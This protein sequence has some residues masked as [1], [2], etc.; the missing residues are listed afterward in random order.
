MLH[1]KNRK[2][3]YFISPTKFENYLIMKG[4]KHDEKV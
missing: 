3:R 2:F 4:I 1:I